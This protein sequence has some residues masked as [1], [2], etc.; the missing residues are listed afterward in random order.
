[1]P[2]ILVVDD[3]VGIR[4]LLRKALEIKGHTVS[5][6]PSADQSLTI[7]RRQEFDLLILD[8]G[9]GEESGLTLLKKIRGY[10]K[11]I[12]IIIY[13]GSV[14][15][16]LEKEARIAGANEVLKK[17]IGIEPLVEQIGKVAKSRLAA[18]HVSYEEGEKPILIVDDDDGIRRLLTGFFKKK[19]YK[20]LEAENGQKALELAR[21]QNI[22]A[23][24][25]DIEMPG[26]DGL[27]TLE[28]LLKINPKLGV[29]M[30][31]GVQNDEKV[32][33]AMELGAYGYVLKPFDFLYL[34]LVIISKLA[35]AR[36]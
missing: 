24:L 20:T 7:I 15:A 19:G 16:D 33:R 35:I 25:L 3:E 32:K 29:V 13:S 18:S 17:D 23:V 9:L 8:I 10:N 36:S 26:I 5:T 21:S 30:V 31:T 1:M 6:V 22:S 28:E 34:E 12:P 2:K 14:T 4:E 27:A 11:E